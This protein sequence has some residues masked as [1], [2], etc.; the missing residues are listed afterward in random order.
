MLPDMMSASKGGKGSLKSG[1]SKGGCV[2]FIHKSV[3]NADKGE[4]VEKSENLADVINGS[5]PRVRVCVQH[6]PH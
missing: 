4:G 3:P 6:P 5:S 1:H 2:N